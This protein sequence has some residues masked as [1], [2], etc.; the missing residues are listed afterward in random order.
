MASVPVDAARFGVL[1]V[2]SVSA[3]TDNDGVQRRDRRTNQPLWVVRVLRRPMG[4][5]SDFV[6]ITVPS[7]LEPQLTQ[8]CPVAVNGL[9]AS[10]YHMENGRSGLSFRADSVEEAI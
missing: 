10:D 2:D 3:K 7:M 8:D 4:G 5:R 9:V 6:N 1:R